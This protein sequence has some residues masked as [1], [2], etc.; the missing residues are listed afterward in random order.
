MSLLWDYIF[1]FILRLT[2]D[3]SIENFAALDDA[4]LDEDLVQDSLKLFHIDIQNNGNI[5]EETPELNECENE[6]DIKKSKSKLTRNN[7]RTSS[8]FSL[9]LKNASLSSSFSE[10]ITDKDIQNAKEEIMKRSQALRIEEVAKLCEAKFL[11]KSESSFVRDGNDLRPVSPE[12]YDSDEDIDGSYV[13]FAFS[14]APP[15]K[16]YASAASNCNYRQTRS[17]S[18][19][20]NNLRCGLHLINWLWHD[21]IMMKADQMLG[22]ILAYWCD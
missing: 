7:S 2:H 16:E 14:P 17:V 13:P 19:F 15:K 20:I 5:P 8:T 10:S 11:L 3:I 4:T 6:D 21:C 12:I 1:V 22:D 9:N 18:V